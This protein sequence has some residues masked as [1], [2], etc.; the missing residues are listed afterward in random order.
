MLQGYED[1]I[2]DTMLEVSYDLVPDPQLA[3]GICERM[4]QAHAAHASI[5]TSDPG[6]GDMI[7]FGRHLY[8]NG[9]SGDYAVVDPALK[10]RV[11]TDT[12]IAGRIFNQHWT[13]LLYTSPSPRDS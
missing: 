2:P 11:R 6:D 1:G 9:L 10:S 8:Q 3:V 13:C 4:L 12:A 5:R 7:G